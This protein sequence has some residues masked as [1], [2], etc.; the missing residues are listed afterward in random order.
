MPA[1]SRTSVT[2]LTV[3]VSSST[4]S[5][6]MN[7]LV[8]PWDLATAGIFGSAAEIRGLVE[9]HSHKVLSS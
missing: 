5:V 2:F 9:N 8:K 4:G 1:S 3:P 6:T 7:A